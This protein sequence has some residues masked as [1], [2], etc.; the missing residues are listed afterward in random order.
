MS[1]PYLVIPK[2]IDQPTWGGDYIIKLKKWGDITYYKNKKIGQSFELYGES[3]LAT[4]IYSTKDSGFSPASKGIPINSVLTNGKTVPLLIKINQA[5]GNSF[6]LHIK[7][8][9]KLNNWLPK[10]ETWYFLENGSITLGLNAQKDIKEYERVCTEIDS[11]MKNLSSEILTG[12]T[13]VNVARSKAKKFIASKNPWKYVNCFNVN[14]G[15]IIDLSEGAI[16]HSWE[17][18]KNHSPLG[19]VVFEVQIDASDDDATIRSFDQGKIK[20]DGT[21]RSL[22]IEDYFLA[23]DKDLIKN[24]LNYHL[25]LPSKDEFIKTKFYCVDLITLSQNDKFLQNNQKFLENKGFSHYYVESGEVDVI[26]DGN[27]DINVTAGHSFFIPDSLNTY[28][29]IGKVKDTKILKTYLP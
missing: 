28:T 9:E 24:S 11:Y 7:P 10:P 2:L 25:K 8:G 16:H 23:I 26:S 5:L 27:R 22:N 21:I 3:L 20:D 14:K 15:S 29:I 17:D 13:S 12:K 1:R 18:N 4:D 6:Q 19:N